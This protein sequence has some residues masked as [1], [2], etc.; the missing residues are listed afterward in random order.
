M[1][2][3]M[4]NVTV[5]FLTLI[6]VLPNSCYSVTLTLAEQCQ[7]NVTDLRENLLYNRFNTLYQKDVED[8]LN[9]IMNLTACVKEAPDQV[10]LTMF[11]MEVL[12]TVREV[13][14]ML[15][16]SIRTIRNIAVQNL[17]VQ[18]L[19]LKNNVM[20]LNT[21][22]ESMRIDLTTIKDAST[23]TAV[24]FMSF[25]DMADIF[26]PSFFDTV[27]RKTETIVISNVVSG[28]P[29]KTN[30][31]PSTPVNFT[32]KHIMPLKPQ[33][34]LSCMDLEAN[35][36]GT[37][38]LIQTNNTH[39]V[40]SCDSLTTLVVISQTDPCMLNLTEQC[41]MD[42]LEQIQY[43]IPA[44]LPQ[45][46][47]QNYLT[48]IMN[49][50]S[51]VMD[52]YFESYG[53]IL[54]DVIETLV[55]ALV[56]KSHI[57][58]ISLQTLE[59]QV[60]TVGSQDFWKNLSLIT[61]HASMDI[62]LTAIANNNIE[63]AT[64]AF[65]SYTNMA[66]I[67]EPTFF[68]TFRDTEK[69][70]VSMVV[71][72]TLP[73]ATDSSLTKPVSFTLKHIKGIA[74]DSILSCMYWREN[75]WVGKE[76]NITKTNSSHSV[77]SCNRVGTFALVMQADP[78]KGV[79][80]GQCILDFLSIIPSEIHQELPQEMVKKYLTII[81]NFTTLVTNDVSDRKYLASYGN[82]VLN[83]T[84]Q[85][86]S[87]LVRKRD[88]SINIIWSLK[89]LEVTIV[90]APN[91][92][93]SNILQLSTQYVSMDISLTESSINNNE[94]V[95]IMSYN[96]LAKILKPTFYK[97]IT[98]R[99]KTMMSPVVSA[100]LPKTTNT[101]LT[102]PV[103]ITFKHIYDLEPKGV[104]S[105]VHWM[106]NK[107]VEKGCSIIW[108]NRTHTECSCDHMSMFTL[109][110]QTDPCMSDRLMNILIAVAI[111]VGLVFLCLSIVTF[112]IY[113]RNPV[114][115]TTL[116]NL[117]INLLLFHLL[118]LIRTLFLTNIRPLQLSEVLAGFQWF[119]LMSVFVWMF[120]EAV[121]LYI[122]MKN[123]SEIRSN[124][125]EVFSWKWLI[126]IGYFIPLGVLATSGVGFPKASI[127]EEC[128][129]ME[130]ESSSFIFAGP[131]LFTI[132]LNLVPL[133]VTVIIMIFILK[134]LK[135]ELLQMSSSA[136]KN[137]II[138]LMIRSLTQFIIL[139]CY[140][141]LLY[142]PSKNGVLYHAF[143]FLNSQQGTFI[144]LIHCVLNKEVRQM[145]RNYLH[146]FCHSNN[147]ETAS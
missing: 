104:L 128:W 75:R 110:M 6:T 111:I 22:N 2:L 20:Q 34:I 72:A 145:Y 76:C 57:I 108:F 87:T 105:C 88:A 19:I 85:L 44:V 35:R 98:S 92:S 33:A 25:T 116:I 99:N 46:T 134:K 123:L 137:L 132:T 89:D 40:C 24:A 79:L 12:D 106:T 70:I 142:I 45:E 42:F 28:I 86:L 38:S 23:S 53:N 55:S 122:F 127:N 69:S 136:N 73:K 14:S 71:T 121:L 58:N 129:F 140:W 41:V 39:T 27:V 10:G 84:E 139:I 1:I 16:N 54:M 90:A 15:I 131:V 61:S 62:S 100:I 91:T 48:T 26:K 126:V 144:F 119:F 118:S 97:T 95:A 36:W 109:I 3:L 67:L 66:A 18:V 13:V 138:C 47:V 74:P 31:Y 130:D 9:E 113:S 17:E 59:L 101:T 11:G 112:A 8:K 64:V 96:N 94:A 103:K 65:L 117:C 32:F 21:S 49:L 114:T 133:L 50:D 43:N 7:L 60:I 143:Q 81:I 102:T 107:W 93:S 56:Q 141:I 4:K 147:P 30:S 125:E 83:V 135:N 63:Q 37:C 68:N 124:Q 5:L 82:A 78:C 51:Y 29:F 80:T 77:C 120:I 52:K 146:S 115:N